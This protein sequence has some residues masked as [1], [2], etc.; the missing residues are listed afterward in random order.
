MGRKTFIKVRPGILEPKHRVA[1]GDAIYLYLYMLNRADWKT[2]IIYDW[3]D[4]DAAEDLGYHVQSIRS[5]R[6]KLAGK[7]ITV[8]QKKYHLEI[9][10]LNWH[11]PRITKQEFEGDSQSDSNRSL[12][13]IESDSQSDSHGDSQSD[14]HG[15]RIRSPL[16]LIKI[17]RLTDNTYT[18]AEN[19][20]SSVQSFLE[21]ITGIMPS[22]QADIDAISEIEKM[23]PTEQDIRAGY[24]W[25]K[26]RGVKLRHYTSL[27]NPISVCM[28]KRLDKPLTTLE[29]SKAAVMQVLSE[30]EDK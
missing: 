17:Y 25:I 15:E 29:K 19:K 2:G 12:S 10:I 23:N 11:D 28:S 26:S 4:N 3:R 20:I 7:Y 13:P 21:S 24:E 27:V 18:D 6:K 30:L 5:Q 9:T 8:I 14:S 16:H 1:I 22:N